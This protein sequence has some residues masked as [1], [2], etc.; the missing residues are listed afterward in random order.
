[1]RA[2][3]GNAIIERVRGSSGRNRKWRARLSYRPD[4]DYE[5]QPK[6]V[7]S[8]RGH[9]PGG[10]KWLREMLT[11]LERFLRKNVGRPWNKVY[12]EAC[13][14]LDRRNIADNHA[15]DHLRWMVEFDCHVAED[16]EV[17]CGNWRSGRVRGFYVHPRTGLLL[18]AAR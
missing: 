12:S 15:L 18:W 6:R 7:P 17:Y 14:A 5:D 13:A 16:G 9:Q 10:G 4:C 8:G 3:M 1:M 11:P 2:D